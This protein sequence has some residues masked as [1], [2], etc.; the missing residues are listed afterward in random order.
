MNNCEICGSFSLRSLP[1]PCENRSM[2]SDGK[3][4]NTSLSKMQCETCKALSHSHRLTDERVRQ[5]YDDE[6][7]LSVDISPEL[8]Q[9]G[10]RFSEIIADHTPSSPVHILEIGCGSGH[11]L[12][13]LGK[14]WPDAILHGLEAASQLAK[15]ADRETSDRVSVFEGFAEETEAHSKLK[16][17][18]DLLYAINVIEH[19]S[20]PARFLAS[21]ARKLDKDGKIIIVC[22]AT[23]PPNLELLFYD[24]IHSISPQAMGLLANKLGLGIEVHLPHIQG[25]GDFQLFVLS[26]NSTNT[27]TKLYDKMHKD[28]DVYLEKWQRL[29][30]VLLERI[31]TVGRIGALGAG[32][33]AA[34]LRCYTPL[35]WDK[36]EALYVDNPQ[37]SRVLGKQVLSMTDWHFHAD[38]RLLLATHPKSQR[39]IAK[40]LAAIGIE[41]VTFDDIIER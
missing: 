2:L 38:N 18:Y 16:D 4:L 41:A 20:S 21:A 30:E 15:A 32:E 35:T 10:Y 3:I 27:A 37:G 25:M 28:A 11:V 24:H 8:K 14:K 40:R 29:D 39:G 1:I 13:G 12:E 36:I 31:Q 26:T 33:M 22:P 6:Y 34:L 5:F 17:S 9:R 19:A 23:E 7:D